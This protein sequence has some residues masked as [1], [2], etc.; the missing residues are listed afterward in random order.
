MKRGQHFI[1]P[2][3]G[4]SSSHVVS[5]TVTDACIQ[6]I[7]C[8][9]QSEE[10]V[11]GRIHVLHA[12]VTIA[13]VSSFDRM[14][15]QKQFH[16]T[17]SDTTR[18]Q[19]SS[20][21]GKGTPAQTGDSVELR[22]SYN[23]DDIRNILLSTTSSEESQVNRTQNRDR[24]RP[25]PKKEPVEDIIHANQM[26]DV[27]PL[28]RPPEPE[29]PVPTSG[30]RNSPPSPALKQRAELPV[31]PPQVVAANPKQYISPHCHYPSEIEK[32]SEDPKALSFF[33]GVGKAFL[34]NSPLYHGPLDPPSTALIYKGAEA[35]A[36]GSGGSRNSS[37]TKHKH[38]GNGWEA[39]NINPKT[40]KPADLPVTFHSRIKSSGYGQHDRKSDHDLW[41]QKEQKK[42][43]IKQQREREQQQAA[44]AEKSKR[45]RRRECGDDETTE[46]VDNIAS[47]ALGIGSGDANCPINEGNG[48]RLMGRVTVYADDNG[49]GECNDSISQYNNPQPQ[50]QQN[51]QHKQQFIAGVKQGGGVKIRQYPS[52]CA[53]TTRHQAYNDYPPKSLL[54]G[55]MS[56]G[57]PACPAAAP[58]SLNTTALRPVTSLQYNTDASF[59]G[60][61]YND[62]TFSTIRL[63]TSRY[64]NN[65][66]SG[67]AGNIT[68]GVNHYCGHE[69]GSQIT[70]IHFSNL[71]GSCGNGS[72]VS[73]CNDGTSRVWR[74]GKTQSSPI[75]IT[76]TQHNCST[77]NAQSSK[78]AHSNSSGSSRNRPLGGEVTASRFY[79]MDRFITL[80]SFVVIYVSKA[81][82]ILFQI[83][84]CSYLLNFRHASLC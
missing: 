21:M 54:P 57:S 47:I 59:L 16:F 83:L 19:S 76:H 68:A 41:L 11:S 4:G 56:S 15:Y 75:I 2:N 35:A 53:L 42:K 32:N 20:K 81:V 12:D 80:V 61:T 22:S 29:P 36:G 71:H 9:S 18:S 28:P 70:S 13:Y 34:P 31:S 79:Y 52:N 84:L 51:Q 67:G 27:V 23:L 17:V 25:T 62:N 14:L 6:R 7:N 48:R 45:R 63:P 1:D 8:F 50:P 58:S 46:Q 38:G 30:L 82:S 64:S 10:G 44:A 66:N 73:S 69:R 39:P 77:S 3:S 43:K 65:S 55:A 26:G 49:E 33:L 60:L 40:K 72:V 24:K 37:I 78:G 5:T 74:I